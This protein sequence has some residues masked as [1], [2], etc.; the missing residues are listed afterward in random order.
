[1]ASHSRQAEEG[2]GIRGGT[3][4][5]LL[6]RGFFCFIIASSIHTTIASILGFGEIAGE[7]SLLSSEDNKQEQKQDAH[8]QS[9]FSHSNLIKYP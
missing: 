8:P 6:K 7:L 2:S 3:S 9:R 4:D 1:M 5:A